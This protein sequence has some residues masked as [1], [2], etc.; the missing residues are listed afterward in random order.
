MIQI[1]PIAQYSSKDALNLAVFP[2]EL[3]P[4]TAA[5]PYELLQLIALQQM[6][7]NAQAFPTSEEG[8]F[9]VLKKG[10]LIGYGS[11]VAS[12]DTPPTAG[13][14]QLSHCFLIPAERQKGYGT[15]LF[16][17]LRQYAALHFGLLQLNPTCPLRNQM[18]EYID[19]DYPS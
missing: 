14:G 4:L 9:V 16:R 10:Q 19:L 8:L 17:H 2:A 7:N 6:E 11:V 5:L 18:G 12:A 13:I 1:I 15:Q 3:L